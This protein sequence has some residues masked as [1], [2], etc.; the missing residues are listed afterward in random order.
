MRINYR[1]IRQFE[2]LHSEAILTILHVFMSLQ[3]SL[4]VAKLCALVSMQRI[5]GPTVQ[6]FSLPMT[7][8]DKEVQVLVSHTYVCVVLCAILVFQPCFHT[9]STLCTC[10]T[11]TACMKL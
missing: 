10:Y 11:F 6:S 5:S 8:V 2:P 4:P 1:K 7:L 9:L 3:A